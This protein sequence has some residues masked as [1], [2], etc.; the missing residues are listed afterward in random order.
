MLEPN[1]GCPGCSRAEVALPCP[2]STILPNLF[3]AAR[4]DV[5]VRPLSLSEIG[6]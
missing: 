5:T 2:C 4:L 3:V 6:P 1:S